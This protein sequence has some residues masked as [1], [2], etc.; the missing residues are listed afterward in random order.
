M[1]KHDTRPM[2][3][4]TARRWRSLAGAIG[5][6]LALAGASP[7]E[8][9]T[10][11]ANATDTDAVP[12]LQEIVVTATRREEGIS[13][14][15]IS[16][17]ALNQDALDQK[18]I[19]DFSEMVRFTPG[20]SIDTSG[21][22]AI[23]IRGISSSGGAGTTGIY[24]DDTP[25]QMRALGFNPDDTLPKTF[26][27]DRVEV[28]R[29]PQG[30]LFGAGSE[31]GTVRYIMN[32]PSVTTESTY[33]RTEAGFTQ[34]GEPSYEAGL[35]HG[36]PLIDG[37]LGYRAS[38]WYRYDGGWIDRVDPTTR[39]VTDKNAN[40]ADTIAM[41]FALLYQPADNIKITPSVVYQNKRQHDLGTYWPAYSDPSSGQFNNATPERIPIPDEYYLPALKV[42]VD[43]AHATLI[44]NT[45]YYHRD[46][47]DSYQG[48]AYDL[49][50]FQSQGWLGVSATTGTC[51]P[52]AG[53]STPP[54]CAY[55]WYPLLDANGLHLP[56]G[57][58]NYSTPNTITN[59][60]RTVTQEVRL[61]SN[62][63]SALKWTA[64]VF[65]SLS[66][67]LSV[68][69]LHDSQIVPFWT[70]L[71][72][73]SPFDFSTFQDANGNA[74]YYC[75][76]VGNAALAAGF[77]NCDIYYNRNISHDRQL[78][79]FGE[80]TYSF[81]DQ[82]KLTLG[83][84]FADMDFDLSHYANGLENSGLGQFSGKYHENAFT[85]KAGV[86]FQAD[87]HDLYYFTYAKGF[88]PGG[89]NPPLP[90][91]LCGVTP[92]GYQSDNTASFEIG[93]KN[94][95]DN[96]VKVATSVYYI[97]WNNIQQNIYDPGPTGGCGFQYTANQG[98]AVAKGFDVQLD[99]AIGAGFA[100]EASIG[101]TSA[102]YSKN[103]PDPQTPG[104]YLSLSGDAISGSAATNYS[105]GTSPPWSIAVGPQY[106]FPLSGHDAFVRLDW[107]YTSRNPWAA[108]VQDP[109]VQNQYDQ[110]SYTLPA[111][112]FFS[113]RSGI[114]VGDWQVS[115]F[116]DN[117]LDSHTVLNYALIQ[118]DYN[119]PNGPPPPQQNDFTFRPRTIGIT[120][121]FHR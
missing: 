27:L 103:V 97:R 57:F 86:S 33:A 60:Q 54:T 118:N 92:S 1:F 8:P 56:A 24:I 75:N 46:E 32:Q 10:G 87:P 111:T 71:F 22:N 73:T 110:Y 84:R 50:Y 66:R 53:A 115:A 117:L 35:A 18:G 28:L 20:V 12:G 59:Q 119:N 96:R 4:T 44:S 11:T 15:P 107:E 37:V 26:D 42:Q 100:L 41:R 83:G 23:A 65:W 2:T 62:D 77:P 101:Y 114:K 14:V 116:I 29:G 89:V 81:N 76:G 30:T 82:W 112:S 39:E 16:I 99:A 113:L 6:S 105:P 78:A 79:E 5:A 51:G 55:P 3:Q 67:E 72:G 93:S 90:V 94:N 121:T 34:H 70:A 36:G 47:V 61:Q 38:V 108:T 13:K 43:F 85:P 98:T 25:I 109:A 69:E 91:G 102:R 17:T 68:E 88:R 9:A 7:G 48:T 74:N 19:R 31:G 64:G 52:L 106:N 58:S 120:A 21:T 80:L 95:L 49:A 63:D 40:R 104:N 45:S